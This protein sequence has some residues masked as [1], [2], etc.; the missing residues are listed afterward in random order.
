L[1]G[2]VETPTAGN[3]N[4]RCVT[5]S[6]DDV[7]RRSFT[8]QVAIFDGPDSPFANRPQ[9]TLSWLEPLTPEM[10]VLDVACGAGH[11]SEL[12]APHVRQVV[13]VDLTRA[14]LDLGA[15]RLRDAGVDNVLLQEGNATAL[16]FVDDSFDLVFC[17]TALHHMVEPERA[18]E[19]MARVCRPGGRVVVEDMTAPG[20]DV[21]DTFDDLHRALDPSHAH[22]LLDSELAALLERHVG[23]LA[24][25]QHSTVSYPFSS[26]LPD[27][28]MGPLRSELA[29][30]ATTGFR[31]V[32]EGDV[33]HVTFTNTA[34]HATK[35]SPSAVE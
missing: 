35:A 17:R 19:E 20:T 10:A 30:G 11:A 15:A 12:A 21:R 33:V 6:H 34:V 4:A 9:T 8:D 1:A 24:H 3:G 16:P 29:G 31:P 18:V 13:G 26:G 2:V 32:A 7:V 22:V 23:A 27:A 5:A 14:L 28:V 25:G